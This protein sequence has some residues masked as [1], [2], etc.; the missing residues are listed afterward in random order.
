MEIL[1][2]I[3][4]I[5]KVI[6]LSRQNIPRL[7]ARLECWRA[8]QAHKRKTYCKNC[9]CFLCRVDGWFLNVDDVNRG[10]QDMRWKDNDKTAENLIPWQ[11]P[12][13]HNLYIFIANILKTSLLLGG[14]KKNTIFSFGGYCNALIAVEGGWTGGRYR[15]SMAA[16]N[17]TTLANTN[18]QS[19]AD[20]HYKSSSQ[21]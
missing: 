11:S 9:E 3:A 16:G 5:G 8:K 6:G 12:E 7:I 1:I 17:N 4:C 2:F 21:S 19:K 20:Y 18:K 14:G 13:C 15:A 10:S